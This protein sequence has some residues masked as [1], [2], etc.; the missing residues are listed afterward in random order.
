MKSEISIYRENCDF[1]DRLRLFNGSQSIL[2]LEEL[3]ALLIRHPDFVVFSNGRK[4]L[5]AIALHQASER[6]AEYLQEQRAEGKWTV[7]FAERSIEAAIFGFGCLYCGSAFVEIPTWYEPERV[8]AVLDLV[9]PAAILT[10]RQFVDRWPDTLP[11]LTIDCETSSHSDGEAN[12]E[13]EEVFTPRYQAVSPTH[14]DTRERLPAGDCA[15]GIF[16]SGTTGFSKLVKLSAR[17]LLYPA[18]AWQ[19]SIQSGDRIGYNPW[20]FYY[21]LYPLLNLATMVVIPDRI[22]RNPIALAT[23]I[24]KAQL[25]QIV[26]TPTLLQSLM[27]SV[28]DWADAFQQVH[29]LWLSGEQVSDRLRSQFKRGAPHCRTIDL[30]SSNE[31]GDVAFREA[32]GS[33]EVLPGI[34]VY[35]L[36]S[37]LQPVPVGTEGEL[38]LA[39]PSLSRGYWGKPALTEDSFRENPLIGQYPNLAPVVYRTGDTARWMAENRLQLTG[40]SSF[41][42]KIRGYKV[43]PKNV[44]G[45]LI[46]HPAVAAAVVTDRKEG[47]EKQLV[48]YIVPANSQAL[49]TA[50]ELRNWTQARLPL[51]AVPSVFYAIASIPVRKS[52]K[53][54]YDALAKMEE[55][56]LLP[57]ISEPLSPTEIE[58]AA[59]WRAVLG[60]D[61]PCFLP[62]DDFFQFGGSLLLASM[63]RQL[64][65]QTGLDISLDLLLANPTLAGMATVVDSLCANIPL[66]TPILDLDLEAKIRS[67]FHH[68]QL[69]QGSLETYRNKTNKHILLTGASG[70]LG[71]FLLAAIAQEVSVERVYCL[72][73]DLDSAEGDRRLRRG[74]QH[75]SAMESDSMDSPPWF[76]KI[77]S[78]CGDLT[79]PNAGIAEDVLQPLT[80]EIDLVIHSGAEVNFL[81]P[82]ASLVEANVSGTC[83][84]LELAYQASAPFLFISTTEANKP[85]DGYSQTKQ[86]AEKICQQVYT[87]IKL[88]IF[89][90]RCGDLAA[91]SRYVVSHSNQST[92]NQNDYFN[93]LLSACL[94]LGS[95]PQDVRWAIN[96]TPVDYAAEMLTYIAMTVPQQEVGK[97]VNLHNPQGVIQWKTICNWVSETLPPKAFQAITLEQWK[98]EISLKSEADSDLK[99]LK[100]LLPLIIENLEAEFVSKGDFPLDL[101]PCPPVD[102]LWVNILID[103]LLKL[104]DEA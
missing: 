18:I 86:V 43:I 81:Q 14:L 32:D 33:F 50:A 34:E 87:N 15:L 21:L 22:L 104:N 93:L 20:F 10:Q 79:L 92:I 3:S 69:W 12:E 13:E 85:S 66:T 57:E 73:R 83:R 89:T 68:L 11:L 26:L 44:E 96:L 42:I 37:N 78:V 49:P 52:L 98:E 65:K 6:V 38:Y 5:S 71:L 95:W 41:Q 25:T 75:L 47:I 45:T 101:I 55:L 1:L 74:L 35:I 76:S 64:S 8:E 100:I 60:E 51:F 24:R 77:V 99:K 94:T 61:L 28:T 97:I 82:Y 16:T 27:V 59:A 90:I 53:C 56:E 72:V 62:A 4:S 54:D 36:D 31:T 102:R 67:P 48:A 46:E 103:A 7:I 39:T 19:G 88:P 84:V 29:T 91:P 63:E 30:Y 17:S 2:E 80:E 70:Y 9:K 58:V 23:F 40:R